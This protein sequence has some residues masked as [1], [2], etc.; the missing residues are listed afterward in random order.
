MITVVLV[1]TA[2]LLVIALILSVAR[3]VLVT[4][5]ECKI[6]VIQGEERKEI[7]VQGGDP[8]LTYLTQ[9][10]I[11]ISSSCGGK[12]TC[13]YCKVKVL[14][15][16]GAMLPTEE[17]FMS[18]EEKLDNMRLA[19]Q[20]K[21]RNDME[22]YI[23]DFLTVVRN[24]VKNRSYDPRLRWN[25]IMTPPLY[26]MPEERRIRTKL[27]AEDKMK[28]DKIIQEHK[29]KEGAL[30]L[31]LQ[32]VNA[33][34]T[35]F[36]ESVLW[37]ISQKLMIPLSQIFRIATFYNAFSLKPRGRHM[38]SVC[39]GTTCYVRGSWRILRELIQELNISP[40]E[41]TE[42]LRFTLNTVRCLGCCSIAPVINIDG[43][44]YGRLKPKEI[45]QILKGYK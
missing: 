19:C 40:G 38:I 13:G 31:I 25:F 9:N 5:G 1:I 36:P 22:I 42:D 15:G 44:T 10:G 28:L 35:Y 34:Y 16:G 11:N 26:P 3:R 39:M 4:Y 14:K 37:Y 23:P 24:I 32:S 30:I 18:R 33:L 6:T 8:L 41:T 2:L 45:T 21:V 27:T 29:D 17:V 7:L 12:A 43:E 20:V